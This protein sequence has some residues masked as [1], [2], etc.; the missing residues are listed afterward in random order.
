MRAT[1]TSIALFLV[2]FMAPG[3]AQDKLG[4]VAFRRP[5]TPGARRSSSGVA[6]L[7]SY[8]F[9]ERARRSTPS[10]SEDPTARWRTGAW[11]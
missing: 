6:M 2:V 5:A 10:C 8:W 7:H 1:L 11:P 3:F 4:K 9:T